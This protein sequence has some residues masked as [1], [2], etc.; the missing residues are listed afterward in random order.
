MSLSWKRWLPA[1][2]LLGLVLPFVGKPVHIDDANFLTLAQGAR[3]DPW[4]PHAIPVN[5]QGRTEAA[6]EVLSNPPGIGWWLA[7]VVDAPAW[8]QHLWML[9][10]LGLLVLGARSLGR[11][12]GGDGTA[13]VLLIGSAPL[14]VLAAQ[15]LTPDLPLIAVTAAGLGGYLAAVDQ[16][17]RGAAAGWALL[18]GSAVLFRYSGLCLIPLLVLYPL[19]RRRP[20]WPAL[21]GAL[22]L[23]LLLAHDLH[24][25]GRLHLVAMGSFQSVSGTGWLSYR[26]LVAALA[27]LGAAGV[28]PLIAARVGWRALVPGFVG[29]F[30]GLGAAIGSGL[31][32]GAALWTAACAGAGAAVL[33]AHALAPVG[34]EGRADLLFLLAW[35]LGGLLFL[36]LLRFTAGRYW[37]PF[38][39][40]VALA[41]LR[42]RPGR[43][44][45]A[46]A[47][48]LQVLLALAL[49]VDDLAMARVGREAALAVD[50]EATAR[51]PQCEDG[52]GERVF[53]GH[54]GWQHQLEQLGWRSLEDEERLRVGA[55]LAVA[56]APWPQ[57]PAAGSCLELLWER[58]YP[59]RWPGPRVHSLAGRA[60]LHA[61]VIAGSPPVETYVPWTL[62]GDPREH[63]ALYRACD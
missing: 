10:W 44:L 22:P 63:I 18:A 8:L 55:L 21:L 56:E 46:A 62:A 32:T 6:F 16:R 19:L 51:A 48:G 12:F 60:N 14:V 37:L 53:A 58:S 38:L 7:P 29:A 1:V 59:D 54:W 52:A 31:G 3:L 20:P 24:A 49:S 25:Y 42:L 13:G 30:L 15:S 9:P 35:A 43:G 4:R 50:R 34:E 2:L 26:K 45:I 47:V 39:P 41:W 28:L 11:R 17:R 5:W 61:F 23:L 27:M 33:L 36:L 40:A 57:E